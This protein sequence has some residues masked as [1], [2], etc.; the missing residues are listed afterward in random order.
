MALI[1]TD[2]LL[3]L[4]YNKPKAHQAIQKA[5]R[6]IKPLKRY[7]LDEDVPL[8]AIER[9]VKRMAVKWEISPQFMTTL[10]R[11]GPQWYSIG[12]MHS[13]ETHEGIGTVYGNTLY[14][15]WA[16]LCIGM[17]ASI[18]SGEVGRRSDG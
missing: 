5:L 18:K 9:V 7:P 11:S 14:E 13:G 17:Y 6:R 4:D 10:C 2:K 8:E 3:A 16:K 15:T 1:T 12:Y